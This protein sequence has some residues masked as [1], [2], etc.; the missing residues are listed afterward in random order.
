MTPALRLGAIAY[1]RLDVVNDVPRHRQL[2]TE[3]PPAIVEGAKQR[4]H[5]AESIPR[6]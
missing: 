5:E 4:R 3:V 2:L 6:Q 1:H